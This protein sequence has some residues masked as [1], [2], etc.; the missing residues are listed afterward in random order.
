MKR[1][2]R[3]YF[4]AIGGDFKEKEFS[5]YDDNAY[6]FVYFPN[7]KQ[8]FIG[9]VNN[10]QALL[11]DVEESFGERLRMVRNGI[12]GRLWDVRN[13]K[14][15]PFD[16]IVSFWHDEDY[17]SK[18]VE[19]AANRLGFNINN[20][21]VMDEDS[22]P[23]N[24]YA[25]YPDKTSDYKK[26]LFAIH[27]AEPYEKEE[28]FEPFKTNK[29]NFQANRNRENG[30]GDASQAEVNFWRNKGLDETIKRIIHNEILLLI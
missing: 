10:H 8:F 5:D 9:R 22:N 2:L 11:M 14:D 30:W 6:P 20:V 26:R 15:L 28:F 16:A 12:R 21:V 3:E 18:I 23:H 24:V 7:T 13:D 4:S 17:D 1:I 25:Y 19:L 27:N 29:N